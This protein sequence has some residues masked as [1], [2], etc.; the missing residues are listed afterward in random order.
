VVER[1]ILK[2]KA[3][4]LTYF[5]DKE[6]SLEDEIF[7]LRRLRRNSNFENLM[8]LYYQTKY[9]KSIRRIVLKRDNYQCVKCGGKVSLQVDHIWYCQ[10]G[11]E[12]IMNLQTLCIFC[13]AEKTK[14]VDLLRDYVPK[15]IQLNLNTT[16]SGV[17]S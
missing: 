14:K 1:L 5:G 11:R 16:M 6:Y 8:D 2:D 13:H 12:K 3:L 10:L 9:W 15:R 4:W 17:M 7:L